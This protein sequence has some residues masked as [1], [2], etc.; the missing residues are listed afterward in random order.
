MGLGFQYNA[1]CRNFLFEE[2]TLFQKV[3]DFLPGVRG[4]RRV[5]LGMILIAL[6][7]AAGAGEAQVKPGDVLIAGADTLLDGYLLR[8]DSSDRISTLVK[9]KSFFLTTVDMD[10]DNRNILSAAGVSPYPLLRIAPD[11]SSST[12]LYLA[13]LIHQFAPDSSGDLIAF[14][15]STRGELLRVDLK[16]P[17][18]TTLHGTP[19]VPTAGTV[20]LESGALVYGRRS[21]T[22]R[23]V[24]R[25]EPVIRT[26]TTLVAD[27]GV[28]PTSMT[29]DPG[30]GEVF[31][32]Q[33]GASGRVLGM[34][35]TGSVTT[36][37]QVPYAR[38]IRAAQDGTLRVLAQH[39]SFGNLTH[40]DRSGKPLKTVRF[41]SLLGSYGME[42]YASR[43]LTGH[44]STR[45]GSTYSLH[46]DLPG[47]GAGGK[48]YIV[49]AS[50]Q[51]R[52]PLAM[53]NG[54]NL[55]LM[56]D[57]LFLFSLLGTIPWFQNFQGI[58]DSKGS[59]VATVKVPQGVSGA[60]IY[61]SGAYLDPQA[62]GA[63]GKIFN[64]LGVTFE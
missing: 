45:A 33:S 9:F 46:I 61:F 2:R 37:F 32:T 40:Y 5:P 13:E 59:A 58:L 30:T 64:T 49:V 19:G 26:E 22:P 53:P 38:S 29:P 17:G 50:T 8:V 12:I 54:E 60:R 39:G 25:Y 7:V 44:G 11:G 15:G 21:P 28:A 24:F 62:P 14:S 31:I 52:P 16:K 4:F 6:L 47:T 35:A 57:H 27:L 23:S 20:D 41:T 51:P 48:A 34:T 63:I 10:L 55:Y 3:H 1:F 42:I 43:P 18:T 36:L 56:L